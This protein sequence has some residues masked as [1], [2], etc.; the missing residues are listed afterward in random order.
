MRSV[1]SFV[2]RLQYAAFEEM[3]SCASG[4]YNKSFDEEQTVEETDGRFEI[5]MPRVVS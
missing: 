3:E 4:Y 1:E 2:E 5:V